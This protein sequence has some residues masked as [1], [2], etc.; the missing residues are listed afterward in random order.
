[1]TPDERKARK[2]FAALDRLAAARKAAITAI[3]AFIRLN[4]DKPEFKRHSRLNARL[5]IEAIECDP[6]GPTFVDDDDDDDEPPY[7]IFGDREDQIS[8]DSA[9]YRDMFKP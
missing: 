4:E 1:M 5:W 9:M 2:A 6:R 8:Y 3:A 7:G